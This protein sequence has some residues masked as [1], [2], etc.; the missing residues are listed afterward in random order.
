MK[1]RFS[2]RAKVA[3]FF[4]VL[5]LSAGISIEI[6]AI[7]IS[8]KAVKAKIEAHLTD[9]VQYVAKLLDG[10]GDGFFAFFQGVARLPILRD[11][12]VPFSEK[13]KSIAKEASFGLNTDSLTVC[14]ANGKRYAENGTV[15]DVSNRDW[16][17]NAMRG[18]RSVTEPHVSGGA[19]NLHITFALPIYDD[20]HIVSG[21]LASEVSGLE[22]CNTMKN[23][24]IGN[25]G[26]CYV[27]GPTGTTIAH[28]DESLVEKRFNPIES[29]S[30]DSSLLSMANFVKGVLGSS[31]SKVGRY[32][33]QGTEYI[34]ANALMQ[35]TGWTVIIKTPVSQ[36]YRDIMVLRISLI[37]ISTIILVIVSTLT[38]I[39]SIK[40]VTPLKHTVAALRKISEGNGD[41]TVQLPVAGNDELTELAE[42]F[43]RT[44]KKIASAIRTVG[45]HSVTLQE[46]GE[47]LSS[48]MAEAA[49]ALNEISSN[50]EGVRH[51]ALAQS[52]SVTET[53]GTI[54]NIINT[55]E[56][57]NTSIESQSASIVQSSASVEQMVANIASITK[58]LEKSDKMVKH[59]ADTT[60]E[61]RTTMQVSAA[62]TEKIIEASGGLIEASNVIQNIAEQTNLLA[63]NAAI[64]AAHAGDTGKGFAVV[65]D[66]IRKL[67]EES[68][69]QGKNITETLKKLSDEISGLSSSSKTVEEK[70]NDIFNLSE[71]VRGMSAE[72][73][74]AM[75]EQ[76]NGSREVFAAIK[77]I[78]AVTAEVKNS[79]DEMMRGSKGVAAEL[80]KLDGLTTIIRDSTNEMSVGVTQINKAM[81][82]VNRLAVKNKDSITGLSD[83]VGKFKVNESRSANAIAESNDGTI[84]FDVAI[85]RHAEWKFRLRGAITRKEKLDVATISKDDQCVLGKWLHGNAAQK[86]GALACFKTCLADH[87]AF[88]REAG[89]VASEINAG[90]FAKAEEM[91]DYGTPYSN[92]SQSVSKAIK[93]LRDET[94]KR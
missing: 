18:N 43:N 48:N 73:T 30:K 28:A 19:D 88:H 16:Y 35:G 63:M 50:L 89:R 80:Q 58:S 15:S 94:K 10:Q 22:F 86:Y 33:Y 76:E 4:G 68:S 78:S 41:L 11:S 32:Y 87:A 60:S 57:L 90:N 64:E 12:S 59:L 42:H 51:Q 47:Q 82:D 38:L 49:S 53:S 66:E 5:F 23:I 84:D 62:V 26:E 69:V 25:T 14:D 77:T 13:A 54:T 6:S 46:S 79:S 7:K 67:A 3:L 91:L 24:V 9:N 61:G 93:E 44:I 27:L 92:A 55:I 45:A 56:L 29:S 70:F 31:V 40:M 37:T 65:A 71:S 17:Q 81:Q 2:I 85:G 72:L 39:L 1:R 52:D 20:N 8:K 34:A 75:Q 21:V 83:E 74:S 36:A